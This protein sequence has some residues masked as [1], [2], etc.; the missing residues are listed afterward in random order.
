[1]DREYV[2]ADGE[3]KTRKSITFNP[4]LK[5]KLVGVLAGS[6]LKQTPNQYRTVYDNYKHRIESDSRHVDKTLGHRHN[7]AMRYMVK[8]FLIDLYKAWR[9]IE[10]LPVAPSFHEGKLGH[11]HAA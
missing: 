3:V 1:M 2:T 10:G 7:M 6:F 11:R 9:Q 4:F 8:M 5:T